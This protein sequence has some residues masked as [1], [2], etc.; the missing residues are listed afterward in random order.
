M[1]SIIMRSADASSIPDI[2]NY[3]LSSFFENVTQKW[4]QRGGSEG[5]NPTFSTPVKKNPSGL[6]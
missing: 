5:K 1:E 2:T 6:L 3:T 4:K